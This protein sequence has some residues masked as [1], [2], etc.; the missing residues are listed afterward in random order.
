MCRNVAAVSVKVQPERTGRVGVGI[1]VECEC[2]FFVSGDNKPH[3]PD[4]FLL[5]ILTL[6]PP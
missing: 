5:S 3:P 4:S 6:Q 1:W 2:V